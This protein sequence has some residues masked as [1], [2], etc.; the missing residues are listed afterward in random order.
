MF[1]LKQE[2]KEVLGATLTNWGPAAVAGG[3][4]QSNEE[5]SHG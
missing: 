1:A 4:E 2:E 5:V 3:S